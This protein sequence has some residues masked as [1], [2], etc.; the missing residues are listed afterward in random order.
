MQALTK[1]HFQ[2]VKMILRYLHG[3]IDIDLH[4]MFHD[5][6]DLYTFFDA[7]EA[8]CPSTRRSTYGYYTFVANNCLMECK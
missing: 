6:L 2:L 1:A 4:I 7:D 3:T 8:G 5:T